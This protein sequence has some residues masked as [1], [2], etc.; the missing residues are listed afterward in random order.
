MKDVPLSMLG[1]CWVSICKIMNKRSAMC[2]EVQHKHSAKMNIQPM[3]D[4]YLGKDLTQEMQIQNYEQSHESKAW[5]IQLL[6]RIPQRQQ[7]TQRTIN[8]QTN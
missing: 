4:P 6:S 5:I 2:T 3:C 1:R 7:A 8:T